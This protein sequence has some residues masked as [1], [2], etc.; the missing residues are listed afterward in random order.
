M[1]ASVHVI[2]A[3]GSGE[4]RLP[5]RL[6]RVG[7][8]S[9]IWS[10]RGDKL[11][12]ATWPGAIYLINPDGSGRRQLTRSASTRDVWGPFAWSPDGRKI[13]YERAHGGGIYA[14]NV[15]GTG[16]RRLARGAGS[17]FSWSPDGRTIAYARDG[18]IYVMRPDGSDRRRLTTDPAY[19]DIP[20]FSPDGKRIAFV[21]SRS[22]ALQIWLMNADGSDQHQ[23]TRSAGTNY[24]PTWSP[25]GS[26]IAFR[27]DRDGNPEIY[28]MRADGSD[29]QRLTD[30]AA[31]EFSPNWGPDGR[32]VFVSNK[33][34][35]GK[36]SL[37]VMDGDGSDQHR[38]TPR[39][40]VWNE[41]SP[42]WSPDGKRV[43]FQADRDVPVGNRE[44]YVMNADATGL[45]RLTR[46]IGQDNW[47][48][49]SPDGKQIAFAR[50]PTPFRNEIYVMNADGSGQHEITE[51]L[52]GGVE[53][54]AIPALPTAGRLVTVVFYVQE[55]SGADI[56]LPTVRCSARA[57]GRSLRRARGRFTPRTGRAACTWRLP[58]AARG[59]RLK[60]A[61][62]V[63]S[64]TG[65][66]I[67]R[68][69]FAVR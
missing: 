23:L 69:N 3:D 20:M 38:L 40:F 59:K 37:W 61:I 51:P 16:E 29:V 10:P 5:A 52:L 22:G 67:Q 47:P 7:L 55:E 68:F 46:Y 17:E 1:I 34:T 33:N 62:A 12:F 64:P 18:D 31:I 26:R 11:A 32:I 63:T 44:L 21:S 60:G 28:S 48:T 43:L 13:V 58:S 39:D 54:G 50:G 41:T 53:F 49:W 14:I 56:G 4:Q 27:S 24:F 66:L 45:K 57:G 65:T 8:G 42:V 2:N 25:D 15:D 35:G 9:P 30:D 36:A 6:P 19:D